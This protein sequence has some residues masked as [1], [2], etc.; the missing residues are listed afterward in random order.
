MIF[1]ITGPSGC[2][3]STLVKG[4][5]SDIKDIQFSVSHTTRKKRNSEEEGEDYYFVSKAE[6]EKMITSEIEKIHACLDN[7][8]AD[9]GIRDSEINSVFLTGG[10]AY[11]PCIRNLLKKKFGADKIRQGDA[12][13]SVASGLALSSHLFFGA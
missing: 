8:L 1:V 13:I 6:F 9:M 5:I 3:K 4:V 10:T 12:F 2:G 7:F 11:V